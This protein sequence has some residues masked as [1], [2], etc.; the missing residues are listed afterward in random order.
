MSF[1]FSTYDYSPTYTFFLLTKIW[2]APR[3][4]R[5]WGQ[6]QGRNTVEE[7]HAVAFLCTRKAKK[8]CPYSSQIMAVVHQADIPCGFAH[9]LNILLQIVYNLLEDDLYCYNYNDV[10]D[11]T[12]SI[13][14]ISFIS[15]YD[16]YV[17]W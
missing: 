10:L 13:H 9:R 5:M 17:G 16:Y 12:F 8:R 7:L 2:W 6:V 1:N 11:V 3:L 15:A 4:L 14:C